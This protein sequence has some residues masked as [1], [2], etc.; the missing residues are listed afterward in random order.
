MLAGVRGVEEHD[1]VYL[2]LVRPLKMILAVK[3]EREA[4]QASS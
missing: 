4:E 1:G 3:D 2:I